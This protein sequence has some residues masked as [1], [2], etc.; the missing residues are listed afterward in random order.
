MC[1]GLEG[2]HRPKAGLGTSGGQVRE[3]SRASQLEDVCT[4][5][6]V[7]HGCTIMAVDRLTW[8]QPSWSV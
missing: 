4:I 6:A 3:G 7:N 5:V 8:T 1:L 2:R